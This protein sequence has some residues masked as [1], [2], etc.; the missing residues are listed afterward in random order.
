MEN[1]KE[2]RGGIRKG[3]GAK[4]KYNEKT[5]P[6]TFRCPIS[7]TNELKIFIKIKLL[8]WQIKSTST[9]ALKDTECKFL[10]TNLT[11]NTQNK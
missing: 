6:I 2:K 8:D 11:L 7:K 3:S 4:P 5:K 10:E 9:I 1:K